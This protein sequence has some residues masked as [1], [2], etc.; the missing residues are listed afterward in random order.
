MVTVVSDNDTAKLG[1]SKGEEVS[2]TDYFKKC[3]HWTEDKIMAFNASKQQGFCEEKDMDS[4]L[5]YVYPVIVN[6]SSETD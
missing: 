3:L 1:C 6:R 2:H 4:G 5:F